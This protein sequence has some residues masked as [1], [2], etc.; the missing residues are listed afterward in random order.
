MNGKCANDRINQSTLNC[1]ECIWEWMISEVWRL[2][3][4]KVEMLD[5]IVL[6][7]KMAFQLTIGRDS[8]DVENSSEGARHSDGFR[9]VNE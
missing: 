4:S 7:F 3:M 5:D 1:L 2:K 9:N 6:I 8:L